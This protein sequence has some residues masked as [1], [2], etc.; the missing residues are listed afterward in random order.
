MIQIS[1]ERSTVYQDF[2]GIDNAA[3]IQA[4]REAGSQTSHLFTLQHGVSCF[5]SDVVKASCQRERI[6]FLLAE[7]SPEEA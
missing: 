6:W 4:C 7:L 3:M 5:W 1:R 2:Y